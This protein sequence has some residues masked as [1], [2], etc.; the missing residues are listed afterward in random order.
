M[1]TTTLNQLKEFDACSEGLRTLTNS[2]PD[3]QETDPI[4]LTH[5]LKSS[6][7]N[8]AIWAL[9]TQEKKY[10]IQFAVG[11]AEHVLN[12]FESKYPEDKRP[13]NAIDAAKRYLEDPSEENRQ[14]CKDAARAAGAAFY[15]AGAAYAA[16]AAARGAAYAACAA[17]DA[18]DATDAT[19][20]ARA[21]ARAARG[22]AYAARAAARA[23]DAACAAADA[24]DATYA[25]RGAADAAGAA[26]A[27]ELEF[28]KELFLKIV[29]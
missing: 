11:C 24:T 10:S 3:H 17:A 26:Y 28:Q 2:L 27:A 25:A 29:S 20:A 12:L 6:G 15:A 14:A 1:L 18:T 23:A 4:P 16:R 19:Y 9:G 5:I 7:L 22:A 13:R 8:L 21:A